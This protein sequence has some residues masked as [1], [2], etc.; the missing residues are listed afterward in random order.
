MLASPV[1]RLITSDKG[2]HYS[3]LRLIDMDVN[4]PIM[5]L[6]IILFILLEFI[7]KGIGE[8]T[9]QVPNGNAGK[10]KAISESDHR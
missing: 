1:Q 4:I 5:S 7:S 8:D 6:C 3:Q 2:F 9:N 10:A